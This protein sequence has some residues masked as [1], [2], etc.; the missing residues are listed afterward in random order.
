MRLAVSGSHRTGKTTLVARLAEARPGHAVIEEPYHLLAEEGHAFAHPPSIED[1]EL[2]LARSIR[3]VHEA[4]PD[5]VFD[6]CP[7]DLV[8]YLTVHDDR[9]AFDLERWLPDVRA[10]V[11]RIDLVVYVP[12]EIPDRVIVPPGDDEGATREDVD[13]RIREI[14]FEDTLDCGC[15]VLEV[16]GSPDDRARLVLRTTDGGHGR[17]R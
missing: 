4:G 6:R 16:T 5:V 1:F 14:L 10:A 15:E 8:A 11:D 7:L 12:V 9:Q 3:E 2:Q 17:R 13:D